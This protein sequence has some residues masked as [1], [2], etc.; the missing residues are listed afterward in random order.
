MLERENVEPEMETDWGD[1]AYV[2]T[3]TLAIA[4]LLSLT[5]TAALTAVPTLSHE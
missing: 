4:L 1:H 2:L 5:Y 3:L